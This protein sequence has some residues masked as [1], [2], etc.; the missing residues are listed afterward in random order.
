[1]DA[2]CDEA[3]IGEIFGEKANVKEGSSFWHLFFL[4]YLFHNETH[5]RS[6]LFSIIHDP[7]INPSLLILIS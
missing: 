4:I 3:I 6:I 5:T 1:M 2:R 7:K